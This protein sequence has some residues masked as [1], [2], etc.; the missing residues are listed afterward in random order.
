MLYWFAM[1]EQT[2]AFKL[3]KFDLLYAKDSSKFYELS[4]KS[5]R[6]QE[7]PNKLLKLKK[8]RKSQICDIRSLRVNSKVKNPWGDSKEGSLVIFLFFNYFLIEEDCQKKDFS[9]WL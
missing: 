1:E 3:H 5:Q 6:K 2:S 9:K 7:I 8:F 4:F